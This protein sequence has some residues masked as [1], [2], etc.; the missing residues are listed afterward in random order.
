M[1]SNS[2]KSLGDQGKK[3][4]SCYQCKAR[5]LKCDRVWPCTRCSQSEEECRFP[6]SRQRPVSLTKRPRVKE[7]Q[8]Q[9][10]ELHSRR[11]TWIRSLINEDGAGDLE[12][13]VSQAE[14][15][16]SQSHSPPSVAD[17]VETGRLEQLPPQSLV[18][19]L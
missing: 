15:R 17:L 13:R 11:E 5:K 19:E 8:A 12:H 6:D 16:A 4:L 18:D 7:L 2:G 9:L 3:S 14:P 1:A 10:S